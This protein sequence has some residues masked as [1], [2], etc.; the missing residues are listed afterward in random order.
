M[1]LILNQDIT[2]FEDVRKYLSRIPN[3]NC[4]GCGISALSMYRWLEKNENKKSNLVICYNNS[5]KYE[6]TI[7]NL[8]KDN[9]KL[10]APSHCGIKYKSLIFSCR[11]Y[12]PQEPRFTGR[13]ARIYVT[14]Q[15]GPVLFRI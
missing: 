14:Y 12:R 13:Y 10:F 11:I 15:M 2:N 5:E 3:I 4:G 7:E 8:G 1:N 6:K 9:D